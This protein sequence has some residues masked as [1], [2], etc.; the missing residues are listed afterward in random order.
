MTPTSR[1]EKVLRIEI[2]HFECPLQC[3]RQNPYQYKSPT[4]PRSTTP[5]GFD[6]PFPKIAIMNMNTS[7]DL[8]KCTRERSTHASTTRSIPTTHTPTRKVLCRKSVPNSKSY[9]CQSMPPEIRPSYARTA[10]LKRW[11]RWQQRCRR[12][13]RRMRTSYRH[14]GRTHRQMRGMTSTRRKSAA[15]HPR[16]IVTRR[17]CSRYQIV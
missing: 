6:Q 13:S 3:G 2:W 7:I 4:R 8:A 5:S 14:Q 17:S 15:V 16:I 12:R 11:H 9:L 1:A 10:L